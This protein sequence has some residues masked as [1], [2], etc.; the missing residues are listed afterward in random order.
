MRRRSSSLMARSLARI[1]SARLPLKLEAALAGA[2]T[3][4]NE[5]KEGERLR[6]AKAVPGSILGR[7]TAELDQSRLVRMQRERELLHPLLQVDTKALGIRLVLK[8]ADNIVGV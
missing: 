5:T 8:A 2:T 4:V 7:K 1:R 3:D 6:F